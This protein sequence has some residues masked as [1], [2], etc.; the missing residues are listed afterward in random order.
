MILID[1]VTLFKPTVKE[2]I[3]VPEPGT[4][5]NTWLESSGLVAKE[6]QVPKHKFLTREGGRKRIAEERDDGR[7]TWIKC[8]AHKIDESPSKEAM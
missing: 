8:P 6:D 5:P 1:E 3:E 7:E 4:E 2:S